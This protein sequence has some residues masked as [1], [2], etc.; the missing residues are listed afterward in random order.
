MTELLDPVA[1]RMS[2]AELVV[3]VMLV[4]A[5][6]Y[7]T[8]AA[9]LLAALLRYGD[10][11]QEEDAHDPFGGLAGVLRLVGP[12]VVAALLV[13]S[14]LPGPSDPDFWAKLALNAAALV[15]ACL[16]AV[17][18]KNLGLTVLMGTISYLL[19]SVLI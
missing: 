3:L 6:T 16:A 11:E 17:R 4:G 1:G 9:P 8:R 15:P 5:G 7:L 13:T 12:A 14:L 10:R 2:Q 19:L 18:W